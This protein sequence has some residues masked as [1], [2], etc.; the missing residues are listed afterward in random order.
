MLKKIILT[1][2]IIILPIISKADEMTSV[3]KMPAGEYKIDE[4]HASVTW[5]VS[6]LGLSNY[7][8]RFSKIDATLTFDPKDPTKSKVV[9]K[10][11]PTS[12]KTDY[13]HADK[14]D[15]N[16]ELATGDKWFNSAKF[17]E[18]KFEST[19]I[20]K[21][22]DNTGKLHGKLTFLGVTKPLVL[23][24]K[25]NGAFAKKP[26]ADGDVAGL[27][28]SASTALKRSDWG[29]STFVPVVGDEVTVNI[30]AEFSKPNEA[31]KSK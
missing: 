10:I 2:A 14:N 9:A 7:T 5:K 11:D 26:Y 1:A 30:E 6:H 17:P 18:I 28:F 25:F 29:L 20:E 31:P 13:P 19:K 24:A 27:G 22:S 3:E 21:T 23:D 16:K 12:I 4:T 8:A 15:F